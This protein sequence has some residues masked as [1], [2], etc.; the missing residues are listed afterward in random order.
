MKRRLTQEQ[1]Q[2]R[3]ER[4]AKFKAI[5]KQVAAMGETER[6]AMAAKYGYVTCAGHSFSVANSMLIACWKPLEPWP[7]VTLGQ[8]VKST[9][10]QL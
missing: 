8:E 3:D 4:R 10:E 9:K 7:T 6:A 2:A 5:W 1:I